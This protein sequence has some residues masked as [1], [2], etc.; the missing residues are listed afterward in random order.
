MKIH[1]LY[2]PLPGPWGGGNQFLKALKIELKR[3]NLYAD[4]IETADVIII[5]SITAFNEF[6]STLKILRKYRGKTIIIRMDGPV[7]MIRGKDSYIDKCIFMISK[8]ICDGAVFQ[9][10]WNRKRSMDMGFSSELPNTVICNGADREFFYEIPKH[11]SVPP[12]R[13]IATSWSPNWN[14]GFAYYKYLD[15]NMD[16]KK[17]S[18]MFVGNSPIDFINC[19]TISPV[20]SCTLGE[21]LRNSD[22]YLTGSQNDPCS[23][24]L[25]EALD[26]GLPAVAFNGGGHPSIV[27]GGGVL[28][29][30][31]QEMMTAIEKVSNQI[32][33][34]RKILPKYYIDETAMQ[35]YSFCK[36]IKSKRKKKWVTCMAYVSIYKMVG[37]LGL[38]H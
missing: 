20:E 11:N 28:F 21:Y 32:E 27:K 23:N 10:E 30:T 22:I 7:C 3:R 14:K 19:R 29:S 18:F 25:I 12:Y 2:E 13:I 6:F 33:K 5:N 36:G 34:Y 8:T 17:Y 31:P 4:I 37:K 15:E 24:S 16:T 38:V 35:Y 1:V 9:T 26:C